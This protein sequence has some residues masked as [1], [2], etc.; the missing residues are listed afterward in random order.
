MEPSFSSLL[1]D[2][3]S[4][5]FSMIDENDDIIT[6]NNHQTIIQLQNEVEKLKIEHFNQQLI[7]DNL[8]LRN[9][10][11][12]SFLQSLLTTT[13]QQKLNEILKSNSSNEQLKSEKNVN[14]GK[15]RS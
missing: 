7:N 13:Q 10:L 6:K 3:E 9:S 2:L 1:Q 5:S 4:P 12:I 8:S 15:I 11:A 14:S